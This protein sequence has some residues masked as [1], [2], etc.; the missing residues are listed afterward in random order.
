MRC[1]PDALAFTTGQRTGR[2]GEGQVL[3]T[4]ILQKLQSGAN[5]TQNLLSHHCY[6]TFQVQVV[7][8]IQCFPDAHA[9]EIHDANA[10]NGNSPGNL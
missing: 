8:K 2:A 3:Q 5:F 9:A 1:Q 4:H 10:A 7:Y 6:V